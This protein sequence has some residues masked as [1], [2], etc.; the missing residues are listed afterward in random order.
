MNNNNE[1]Q[2]KVLKKLDGVNDS[3]KSITPKV[4]QRLDEIDNSIKSI[5][6]GDT[7]KVI[8][9]NKEPIQVSS[10][11]YDSAT[12]IALTSLFVSLLTSCIWPWIKSWRWR[13][14]KIGK[15]RVGSLFDGAAPTVTIECKNRS[16]RKITSPN[17]WFSFGVSDSWLHFW[18]LKIKLKLRLKI[19]KITDAPS[20]MF[21]TN[22]SRKS[23]FW[24][25]S[26]NTVYNGEETTM[27]Y[28]WIDSDVLL[29]MKNNSDFSDDSK[30]KIKV[31]MN[32]DI[33]AYSRFLTKDE[34]KN[35]IEF[36]KKQ[37]NKKQRKKHERNI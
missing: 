28:G 15:V 30:I 12:L 23:K 22:D 25:D 34:C 1:F 4:L 36:V 29:S 27:T 32:S 13:W 33:G 21:N 31:V 5:P 10:S 9:Q 3:I 2:A 35:V 18:L 20:I 7:H 17:G 24:Q 14:L 26:F 11:L 16:L 8:L 19:P 37:Q 6:L